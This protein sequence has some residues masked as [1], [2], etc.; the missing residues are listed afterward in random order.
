MAQKLYYKNKVK[1]CE[2]LA[3]LNK[4]KI[5]YADIK[6]TAEMF[7]L[8]NSVVQLSWDN[9]LKFGKPDRRV[10]TGKYIGA[11]QFAVHTTPYYP[12]KDFDDETIAL[13]VKQYIVEKK[14][15][16]YLID[17]YQINSTQFY[18]WIDELNVSGDLG[19]KKNFLNWKKYL[20]K[21]V[22]L[23]RKSKLDVNLKRILT[24]FKTYIK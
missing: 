19:S 17:K 11:E 9:T 10:K 18:S 22:K 4:K 1:A 21:D 2:Y 3:G 5:E 12:V 7:N 14:S 23:A 24:V 6:K 15:R 8:K 20:K 16:R 13:I